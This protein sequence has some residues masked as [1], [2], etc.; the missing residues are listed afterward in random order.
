MV[1]Q[2][3]CPAVALCGCAELLPVLGLRADVNTRGGQRVCAV[4]EAPAGGGENWLNLA[5]NSGQPRKIGTCPR[6]CCDKPKTI[7]EFLL[8]VLSVYILPIKERSVSLCFSM[9]TVPPWS[10]NL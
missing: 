4:G 3:S 1:P 10:S 5:K 9:L 7:H 8:S 6:M 2:D